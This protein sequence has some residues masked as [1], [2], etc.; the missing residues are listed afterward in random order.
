MDL[1]EVCPALLGQHLDWIQR[2]LD[3]LE[4]NNNLYSFLQV[5]FSIL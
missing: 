5:R 4:A 3:R 2:S 1:S